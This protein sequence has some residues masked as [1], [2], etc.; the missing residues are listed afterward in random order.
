MRAAAGGSGRRCPVSARTRAPRGPNW[1]P[2]PARDAQALGFSPDGEPARRRRPPGQPPGA[3]PP[4]AA[5]CARGRSCATH[6][7]S[8]CP[9]APTASSWR[10]RSPTAAPSCATAARFASSPACAAAPARTRTA[11]S[12]SHPTA[13]SS[14]SPPTLGYTQLWDVASRRRAGRRLTGHEGACS[15]PSSRPTGGCSPRSGGDGTVILWD[16]ASRRALGTLP[17]RSAGSPAR[18]T[19]DG[20]HLFVLRDTGDAERWEVD[21]DAWSRACLSRGGARAHARR[22]ERV[23]PRPGLPP[24]VRLVA[25]PP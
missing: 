22:V 16:V 9:S 6:R 2:L 7:D 12:G 5:A 1:T 13:G 15:A 3:R 23:R 8:A 24:G 17:G 14:P 25:L 18:F 10:S 4:R 19:P 21:P 11:G 20:R